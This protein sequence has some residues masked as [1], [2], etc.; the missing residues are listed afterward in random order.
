M[1]KKSLIEIASLIAQ[2]KVSSVE[3]TK[4]VLSEIEK[5][6][7]LNVFTYVNKEGALAA[8][9]AVDKKIANGEKVGKLA[10]V[11][12]IIKDNICI[13]GIPCTCSSKMLENFKPPFNA[14]VIDKLLA[15]DA[16][17]IGKANMDEFAMGSSNETSYFGPV[18]NPYDK[19]RVSGGSSGGSAAG[20]AAYLGYAALGTDTG[21]SIRQPSALCGIVGIK[22]TYGTV[23]RRGA[24]AFAS[25][26]DQIGPLARNVSDAA[27]MLKIISGHDELDSTSYKGKYPTY[28]ID[29]NFSYKGLKIGI[30]LEFMA[31]LQ[32][33]ELKQ[34]FN[35]AVEK[36]K[37][38]GAEIIELSMKPLEYAIPAYYILSSAEAA[39][40]LARFDGIK[41]GFR[42]D[43]FEDMTD[44]YFK[45]RSQGFGDEVKRRIMLG[46]FVLSSGY[47]DAYYKKAQRVQTLI[48][49]EFNKAFSK[50]DLILTPTSPSTAFKIGEKQN[51]AISMYLSDVFT[52]SVN[53]AGNAAISVP[54]GFVNNLP[55]GIQFIAPHFEEDRMLSAA[56][57]YEKVRV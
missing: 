45:S 37:D 24:V 53:I 7:D 49:E 12:I 17:I 26:L 42:A 15:E 43:K 57:L 22:P 33:G 41:Y 16:V 50:C 56:F 21:G 29:A 55:F 19:E 13:E 4:N 30:P 39:S 14:V 34:T 25:S 3:V 38:N 40:N 47:F 52:V 10:G 20:V 11:P 8:A 1:H 36:L 27:L 35:L 54:C 46:N 44:I 51:D 6:A 48:K 32:D 28:D 31:M 23:S 18:K 2:K 9:E 5:N